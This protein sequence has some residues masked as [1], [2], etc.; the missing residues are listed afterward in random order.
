MKF[1]STRPARG[2]T[3]NVGLAFQPP[4]LFQ[5]TRPARGATYND[6][7]IVAMW[8]FQSTRPARGATCGEEW[9]TEVNDI[10]IHAPREGRDQQNLEERICREKF[11]S[12]R[13]ARGATGDAA[14]RSANFEFQ[15]TRPARGATPAR[16]H[17]IIGFLFQ[18]TRPA[19]GATF[20]SDVMLPDDFISIH[21]PREGRDGTP[22]KQQYQSGHFN[23]RA[24]RGAR[25]VNKG[26]GHTTQEFQSTR[27]ARGA[28][29]LAYTKH[30]KQEDFNPRAPR[31]ARRCCYPPSAYC[32]HF[33]PRAPRGARRGLHCPAC[34]TRGFQSTR[35]ARG[36]TL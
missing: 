1:Q 5:S 24:P 32:L 9:I 17:R 28:T 3:V 4:R 36:A 29:I 34:P 26:Q 23:P 11:Q 33:N 35:P 12:T 15:S 8:E 2:A 27:P 22:G 10:S 18:S 31:G 30:I 21:A 7:A 14:R 13:P 6:G 25:R 19:R 20:G 16:P